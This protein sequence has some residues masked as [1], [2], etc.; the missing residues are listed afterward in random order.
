MCWEHTRVFACRH[1]RFP[2]P[3]AVPAPR[4]PSAARAAQGGGPPMVPAVPIPPTLLRAPGITSTD[5]PESRAAKPGS[6]CAG[7]PPNPPA[8][9]P[10]AGAAIVALR[11]GASLVA[12]DFLARTPLLPPGIDPTCPGAPQ[13]SRAASPRPFCPPCFSQAQALPGSVT[14][15]PSG[16]IPDN[17]TALQGKGRPERQESGRGQPQSTKA[18]R[19]DGGGRG[20]L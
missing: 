6:F 12:Q 5:R 17:C 16:L 2:F 7:G 15:P 4:A 19:G 8:E 3:R 11:R 18:L 9:A 14:G 10:K 13:R 1:G 20:L